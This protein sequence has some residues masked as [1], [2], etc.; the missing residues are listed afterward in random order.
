MRITLNL[1][2][3]NTRVI[4]KKNSLNLQQS[5]DTPTNY[6]NANN[7]TLSRFIVPITKISFG[8]NQLQP[9]EDNAYFNEEDAI[10]FSINLFNDINKFLLQ[11]KNKATES[12][13]LYL[14]N[15][16]KKDK[17]I[18]KKNI[19]IMNNASA[20]QVNAELVD[21]F[22]FAS[23]NK[24]QT[25]M[26]TYLFDNSTADEIKAKKIYL[27]DKAFSSKNEAETVWIK[28]NAIAENI[29][30]NNVYQRNN[31]KTNAISTKNFFAADNINC[32][33]LAANNILLKNSA[34]VENAIIESGEV[35]LYNN[36]KI[37]NL[38]TK[39]SKIIL[40]KNT[41][42]TSI[43]SDDN[44][45]ITGNGTIGDVFINGTH[46]F[47]NGPVKINGQISF[48]NPDGVVIAQRG[49]QNIF[50][51]IDSSMVENGILQFLISDKNNVF[52]GNLGDVFASGLSILNNNIA[53]EKNKEQIPVYLND[54]SIISEINNNPEIKSLYVDFYK[55]N[56]QL[57]SNDDKAKIFSLFW[58]KNAKLGE[59]KLADLWM[60][61]LGKQAESI[62]DT[63]KTYKINNLSDSERKLLL[64]KTT[65]YWFKNILPQI[66]KE[67][68][69]NDFD[70]YKQNLDTIEKLLDNLEQDKEN[71][72]KTLIDNKILYEKLNSLQLDNQSLLDFWLKN[73]NQKFTQDIKTE[74]L[75]KQHLDELLESKN[76]LKKIINIT[77]NELKNQK[78]FI[79]SY[80]FACDDLIKNEPELDKLQQKLLE[81]YKKSKVFYQIIL[82]TSNK[83]KDTK[84][85]E[86]EIIKIL[87][88]LTNEYRQ[89]SVDARRNIFDKTLN[90][91]HVITAKPNTE[92]ANYV[93]F[94]FTA[95]SQNVHKM[96][97]E[98][99]F[100][101]INDTNAFKNF[102]SKN[103]AY[104]SDYWL[105]MVKNAYQFYDTK[106][107]DMITKNNLKLLYSNEQNKKN[108]SNKIAK[109]VN[110]LQKNSADTIEQKEFISRFKDNINFEKLMNNSG[111]DQKKALTD[112]LM[113]EALNENLYLNRL[114]SYSKSITPDSVKE[115]LDL[116]DKYLVLLDKD[117]SDM[118]IKEKYQTISKV[119][120]EEFRLMNR[121]IFDDWKKHELQN[122]L[123]NKFVLMQLEYNANAQSKNIKDNLEAINHNLNNIRINIAG[124]NYTLQEMA[125]NLDTLV[126]ISQKSFKELYFIGE[127]IEAINGN[128]QSIKANTRAVLYATMQNSKFRDPELS[129]TIEELL[130]V[131]ERGSFSDF[132]S[133]VEKKYKKMKDE[134]KKKELKQIANLAMIAMAASGIG[135]IDPSVITNFLGGGEILTH[136]VSAIKPIADTL[137]HVAIFKAATTGMK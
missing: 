41:S 109:F 34:N 135:Y 68:N 10:R 74:R 64:E 48:S 38:N 117:Y 63:Q 7:I 137:K 59:K 6:V 86:I 53:E 129:K 3:E 62:P 52:L 97:K 102:V 40:N 99:L 4:K 72:Q 88:S 58:T 9:G 19:T 84:K 12:E 113:A 119:P 124:Q 70:C 114:N 30:A 96:P 61:I 108:S 128:T 91:A 66:T 27:S 115:N 32:E 98:D 94:V 121:L 25:N 56:L 77:K 5:K 33:N 28:D 60:E 2:Q 43:K 39:N 67:Q 18:S 24:I 116:T 127:N 31:S 47:L 54:S 35:V 42:I 57:L 123:N 55:D 14:L 81:K 22:N 85:I 46:L 131:T 107:L 50:P 92:L 13:S 37:N 65:L 100:D 23:A 71:I 90:V 78:N 29:T 82:E 122:L 45:T 118:S 105:D 101:F 79:S 120:Y 136:A 125:S 132:L 133:E 110:T 130:P 111:I 104:F 87:Q 80:E 51:K 112:L 17:V 93:N 76:R 26:H 1:S 16:D 44:L 106:M 75:K 11:Y 89:L 36:A 73:D 126:N 49:K 21:M 20:K 95:L 83:T 8:Q 15:Q 103:S 134:K 69:F